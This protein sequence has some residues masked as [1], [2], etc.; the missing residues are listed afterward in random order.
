VSGTLSVLA[1]NTCG[2]SAPVS[3]VI[4]QF[5]QSST[6]LNVNTC[7]SYTF[8]GQNYTQ[9]G[10]YNYTGQTIHGCDSV[11]VLNL[12][13]SPS[14]TTT[15]T[16]Q[17]CG[18]YPWNGQ[19]FYNSGTYI[20]SLQ[21]SSG[22]DSIVN[23]SLTIHPIESQIIDSTVLDS[24]TWNGTTYTTSGQY[25]QFF[26]SIHGCDST[27]TINLTIEDSG[28]DENT[29]SYLAYPNPVT[30]GT[31]WISGLKEVASFQIWDTQGRLLQVGTTV[32]SISVND[33]ITNG[34]YLL[35]INEQRLRF[36]VFKH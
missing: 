19:T 16:E 14:S 26:T 8:N 10:T 31:I 30:D 17:A 25:T 20:D 18:S 12:T 6:T 33:E 32:N 22:C 28:L 27:V 3:V 11:V 4:N 23:L 13:I 5:L 21:T 34:T 1:Q 7:N 29:T 9:S 2:Q 15:I 36:Q 24:F 35:L